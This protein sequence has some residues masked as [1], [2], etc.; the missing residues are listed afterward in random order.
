MITT[1]HSHSKIQRP[2]GRC[3]SE[4]RQ[5]V[6]PIRWVRLMLAL[7]TLLGGVLVPA[8]TSPAAA[9]PPLIATEGRVTVTVD[10]SDQAGTLI[11]S[12]PTDASTSS[13]VT[14]VEERVGAVPGEERKVWAVVGGL[15]AVAVALSALTIRY[16]IHTRPEKRPGR[17][18]P[19]N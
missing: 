17:R 19:S 1:G 15:V 3:L 4:A 2:L 13:T 12:Q 10:P 16:W 7:L 11:G 8:A 14:V 18:E 5:I 6:M 9:S